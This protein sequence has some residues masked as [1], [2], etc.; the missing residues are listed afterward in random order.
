MNVL[1]VRPPEP[2]IS[3]TYN[4]TPNIGLAYLAGYLRKRGHE[5]SILDT[6]LRGFDIDRAAKEALRSEAEIIGL[7]AYAINYESVFA[8]VESLRTEGY[9]GHITLGGHFPTFKADELLHRCEGVDSIVRFEGEEPLLALAEAIERG[10]ELTTVPNLVYR[11]GRSLAHNPISPPPSDLTALGWPIRDGLETR[12]SSKEEVVVC[13]SRGCWNRCSYCSIG[14][15]HRQGGG[16]LWRA[17]PAEDVVDEIEHLH[18]TYGVT[19]FLFGD[20]DFLGPGKTGRERASAIASQILDRDLRIQLAVYARVDDLPGDLLVH[21][22]VAGLT[23]VYLGVESGA[24]TALDRWGKGTTTQM[25]RA[26][27]DLCREAGIQVECGILLFDPDTTVEEIEEN[28][29]FLKQTGAYDLSNFFARMEIRAGIDLEGTLAAEERLLGDPLCPD[30]VMAD[31]RAEAYYG[32]LVETLAPFLPLYYEMRDLASG[33][34]ESKGLAKA[35]WKHMNQKALEIAIA[36]MED[37]KGDGDITETRP[38]RERAASIAQH[39]ASAAT[40]LSD[41]S[42][43]KQP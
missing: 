40:F 32:K 29:R 7:S 6:V 25:N 34:S 14:P 38:H 13:S 12:D 24:Q 15:F 4:R 21:L 5:A 9:S 33:A 31:P 42:A 19:R 39:F 30:Y 20:S 17:R 18:H 41:S 2:S 43:K 1:L 27:I 10:G 16:S 35:V 11:A 37:F 8:I 3:Q 22:R 36:L 26:A 23:T 28:L